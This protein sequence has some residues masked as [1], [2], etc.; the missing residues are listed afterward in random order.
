MYNT[1]SLLSLYDIQ[2]AVDASVSNVYVRGIVPKVSKTKHNLHDGRSVN[3]AYL[4]NVKN[5]HQETTFLLNRP[6]TFCY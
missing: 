6:V 3:C 2:L 5:G 4:F 1:I